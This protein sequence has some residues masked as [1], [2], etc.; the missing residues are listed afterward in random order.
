MNVAELEQPNHIILHT[1]MVLVSC[2][3]AVFVVINLIEEE[4]FLSAL[5]TLVCLFNLISLFKFKKIMQSTFANKFVIGYSCFILIT[6][7][8]VFLQG[9]K[10]NLT[11]I[12]LFLIPCISYVVNGIRLGFWLTAIFSLLTLM[13][14]LSSGY[15]SDELFNLTQ[16]FNILCSLIVIWIIIHKNETIKNNMNDKLVKLATIDPL[17]ELKNR[18]QLYKIYRQY[19]DTMM[20]LAI[21]DIDCIRHINDNHGYLAGDVVLINIAKVIMENKQSDAHA[22]RIGDDEF[23][24]LIANVDAEVC[25]PSI[26]ELFAKMV[27][28]KIVFKNILIDTKISIALSSIKSDGNN[29]DALLQKANELLQQA[30]YSQTDKIAVS[31]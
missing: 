14:Y 15:A 11:Y 12:W 22:F 18:E 31:L 26:R 9:S 5:E 27:H 29:L 10:E 20:S 30:K 6:L 23:A 2:L 4:Y 8:V 13:I 19:K 28:H 3:C 24:I 16:F 25:L 1:L 7:V 17:T 21:I